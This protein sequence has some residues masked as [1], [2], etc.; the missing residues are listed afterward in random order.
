[1]N[2]RLAQILASAQ[3]RSGHSGDAQRILAALAANAPEMAIALR[4]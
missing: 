2:L 1:M 4:R 3:A